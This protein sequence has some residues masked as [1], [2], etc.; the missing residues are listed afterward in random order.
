M[1]DYKKCLTCGYYGWLD[2]HKCSSR[3][4]VF[5]EEHG[6][7]DNPDFCYG[8]DKEQA[9]EK[10]CDDNFSDWEYPQMIK[11]QIRL[12]EDHEWE[13]FIVDVRTVPE[14]DVYKDL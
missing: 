10:Y 9:I 7:E 6:D 1:S 14:F 5:R 3:W 8:G 13:K 11:V 2:S 12:D 4:E